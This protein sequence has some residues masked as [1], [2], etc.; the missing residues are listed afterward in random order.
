MGRLA[1]AMN[2]AQAGAVS[3]PGAS[4]PGRQPHHSGMPPGS[5]LY[6]TASPDESRADGALDD[7]SELAPRVE[8][9]D[10]SLAE[11]LIITGNVTP[12]AVEQYRRLAA[13]LYHKQL[14]R[15]IKTVLVASTLPGEG[16][17]LT[18]V[19]LALTFSESYRRQVL[20]IDG[21]LRR[22][23]TH[24]ALQVPNLLGLNVGLK[25]ESN[26][27]LQLV[28][29]SPRLSVLTAGQPEPDPMS[30]LASERMRRVLEEASAR[31]EWVIIDT[32]PIAML[33]DANLLATMADVALLVV[34]AGQAP[35][36]LIQQ[37]IDAVG[38]DRLLGVIFNRAEVDT[39]AGAY[40]YYSYYRYRD[41]RQQARQ[42][43]SE[44]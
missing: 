39:S 31:F 25:P 4:E 9:F 44:R 13:T 26:G 32:P 28:E 17:T 29:M 8:G 3:E 2:K 11:K 19:N 30:R 12:G 22:P 14:E 38:R 18:A 24:E 34:A 23:T 35:L 7:G 5:D 10:T 42:S 21:D 41:G 15:G 16:K 27:K 40:S 1:E 36:K 43:R 20:L 33:P 37:A 6:R